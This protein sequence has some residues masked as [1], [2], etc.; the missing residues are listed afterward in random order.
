MFQFSTV[1]VLGT[2]EQLLQLYEK[3]VQ[4]K[5]V[6]K[7]RFVDAEVAIPVVVETDATLL[8]R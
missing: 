6:L 8:L 4:L 2:V 1:P 3:I 5:Q 7:N